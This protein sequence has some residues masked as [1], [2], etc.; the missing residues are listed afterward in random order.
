[1]PMITAG[2][3]PTLIEV[4]L[5]RDEPGMK[6]QRLED[7]KWV[8]YLLDGEVVNSPIDISSLPPGSYRFID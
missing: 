6:L 2:T 5:G 1:M 8:D 3:G 7:R 4:D